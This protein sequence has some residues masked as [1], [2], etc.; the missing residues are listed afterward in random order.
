MSGPAIV[1]RRSAGERPLLSTKARPGAEA[2]A[3]VGALV[4]RLPLALSSHRARARRRGWGYGRVLWFLFLAGRSPVRSW[5]F[6]YFNR[7]KC[8]CV[9]VQLDGD[10]QP[11]GRVR[12]AY[13]LGMLSGLVVVG[14]LVAA[15]RSAV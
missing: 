2:V 13:L 8:R 3:G 10:L 14:L 12:V 1:R 9:S 6:A 7:H 5:P 11:G 15:A 4:R